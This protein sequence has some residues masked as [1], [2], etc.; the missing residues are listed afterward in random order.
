MK[1]QSKEVSTAY[2]RM[3]MLKFAYWAKFLTE[4]CMLYHA[5]ELGT[6]SYAI[7]YLKGL[8]TIE[9]FQ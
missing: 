5:H 2:M 3:V 7:M 9:V 6:E 8:E 1:W 4:S